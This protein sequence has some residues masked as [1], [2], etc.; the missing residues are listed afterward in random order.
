MKRLYK[1]GYFD[2]IAIYKKESAEGL[3][4][5][6]VV[7]EKPT[8]RN[9]I[10]E[11]NK[12]IDTEDLEAIY[13]VKKHSFLDVSQV[14]KTQDSIINLYSEKGFFLADVRYE[15]SEVSKNNDVEVSFHISEVD[16]VQVTSIHFIGN[17]AFADDELK[18]IMHT[19]EK[20]VW[21]WI[22]KSGVYQDEIF[23]QDVQ[24]GLAYYYLM[25]GYVDIKIQDPQVEISPDKKWLY[26]TIR[27]E[28]GPLYQFGKIG[29]AGDLEFPQNTLLEN[30]I[31]KSGT[32]YN[33]DFVRQEIL[34]LTNLYKDEGYA[35]AN[36]IPNTSIVRKNK[37]VDLVFNFEK[38]QKVH[39]GKIRFL[40][41]VK[42]RD[43]VLRRE[44]KVLEG[45]PYNET[46]LQASISRLNRLAFFSEVD[47][48]KAPSQKDPRALDLLVTV[49]EKNTGSFNFGAGY[50]G[51]TSLFLQASIA[52]NNLFGRGHVVNLMAQDRKS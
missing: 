26:L 23:K 32:I 2:D 4:L 22:T 40:G 19:K 3:V 33:H 39:F 46:E 34:R 47:V 6:Y 7:R 25:H 1:L 14:K 45:E 44:M 38:G 36:V 16:K 30:T 9:I 49:K 42:T 31:I 13:L 20:G 43:K 29:V 17:K 10:I 24:Q 5:T 18:G 48:Q 50:S 15:L 51:V 52:Q 41:N 28:E 21:S 37:K 27:L 11:G 8:I 12:E 35:Y